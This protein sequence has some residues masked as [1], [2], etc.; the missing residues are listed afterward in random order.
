MLSHMGGQYNNKETENTKRL[1]RY[2]IKNGVDIIVGNHE[3]TVHGGVFDKINENKLISYSLGNFDGIAG[4]YDKPYDKMAEYSIMWN[5]YINKEN[6]NIKLKT[7]FFVL[8]TIETKNKKIQ[9][10]P[11]Y[12]L[13]QAE[14]NIEL[15]N[16]L[17]NDIKEVA[18]RFSGNKYNTIEKEY[19]I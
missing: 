5:I 17:I 2:L 4:V 6:N 18:Y 3:H 19:D 12:D 1:C 8:K 14:N 15:K 16:K 9:T 13:I 10:V 7:T 11:V